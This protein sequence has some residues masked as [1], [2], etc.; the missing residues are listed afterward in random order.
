MTLVSLP[1]QNF[2]FPPCCHC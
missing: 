2:A 1:Q